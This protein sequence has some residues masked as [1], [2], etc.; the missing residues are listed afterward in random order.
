[1]DRLPTVE[2]FAST[3][4]TPSY[5]DP[6]ESV[7]DYRRY[8]REWAT[9]ELGSAAISTRMELP[10]GRIRSWEDGS[11]PDVV[12]GIET[13]LEHGWLEQPVDSEAF[14]ALNRLVAGVYSGGSISTAT[15]EPSFSTPDE[16]VDRRLRA[17]LNRLNAESWVAESNSGNVEELRVATDA[18]VL[19]RVLVALDAPQG[20]KAESA[21][22][23]PTY[24]YG[25]TTTTTLR[26]DFVRIY[27][28]NRGVRVAEK[29]FIQIQEQR[30]NRY[31]N[32]LAALLDDVLDVN[33]RCGERALRV[34][35]AALDELKLS[36]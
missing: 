34:D 20:P 19:G 24:L 30:S 3:Y 9:S 4:N 26:E 14:T 28:A 13:A 32:A 33:V 7:A 31:R 22:Q 12:N 25:E 15:F 1:M 17:D 27:M 11:K 23:P 16:W 21:R 36:S 18:T 10:R 8:Q 6:M 29:G 5:A 2:A 35:E